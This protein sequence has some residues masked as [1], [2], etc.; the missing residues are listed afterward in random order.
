MINVALVGFGFA[1]QT[2]HAPLIS[3]TPGLTLHTVV[4]SQADRLAAA[5]P[6]ARAVPDLETALADPAVNLV[7]LAT[8]DPLHADQAEAALRAGKAV[9]VDKPF[10]LTLADAR[11]V[12]DLAKAR[13]LLLSVFQNRRWDADFLSLRAE[14]ASGRLGRVVTFE[15]RFDRYRPVVRDRWRE[16]AGAGV[17]FDLG[18]HLVDQALV[19]FGRPLG[20]TLD[21]AVQRDGGLSPDW[22]HAVLRYEATRVV[23]NA[24]MM[25][26][27]PD[28]RFA[29]HGTRASLLSSG[30][31]PQE[32]QLKAGLPV[33]GPGWG[34]DPSPM[35][36]VE[37]DSGHRVPVEG[38]AGDYPAYYS[39]IAAA[40]R[41]EGDN[42]VP[43]EQALAVMEV[44]E[45]GVESARLH[46][47]VAL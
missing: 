4:T 43:P 16:A 17:W 29:V 2:F 28:V 14:I 21:L 27:A 25:I 44:I 36:R 5:W 12:V 19:L 33:G 26:A 42:P 38:P 35:I 22:A 37:G 40:L 30:L 9:V 47:E 18:P 3:A 34:V 39:G 41:G 31:D 7:V 8:P 1:G 45:A 15:S 13:G 23:L 10:A 46:R 20:V 32:D 11:R 24:A 6:K